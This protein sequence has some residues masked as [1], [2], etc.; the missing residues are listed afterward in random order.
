MEQRT[1]F[2]TELDMKR[3]NDMLMSGDVSHDRDNEHL[4][5]LEE[6]LQQ[7]IVVPPKDI[8]GDVITMNSKVRLKDL[9]S[10]KEMT[11]TL[12]YPPDADASQ[13]KISVLAPIGTALIGFKVG[14][15]IAWHVPSGLKRLEVKEV[16]YQP[17]ASGDYHL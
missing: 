3:L 2:V 9:D 16:I 5:E 4:R 8:P 7:A 11:Y 6:E 13:N 1:I 12:V 10:G 17:E 14:D 15:V